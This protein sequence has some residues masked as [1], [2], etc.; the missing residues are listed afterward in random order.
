VDDA[1]K[2]NHLIDD[3]AQGLGSDRAGGDSR[4]FV[5][6]RNIRGA[7]AGVC[8]FF[9]SSY[10]TPLFVDDEASGAEEFWHGFSGW[11]RGAETLYQ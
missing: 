2:F 11:W 9:R 1:E 3:F 7:G 8:C 5:I 4:T 10:E 6:E